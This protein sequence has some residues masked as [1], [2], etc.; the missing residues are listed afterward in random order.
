MDILRVGTRCQ[1]I[2]DSS[3]NVCTRTVC[4]CLLGGSIEN[5]QMLI[6]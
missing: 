4:L 2:G 3:I 6:M 1:S 5:F